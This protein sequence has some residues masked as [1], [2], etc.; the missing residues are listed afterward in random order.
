MRTNNLNDQSKNMNVDP[1][2]IEI[3]DNEIDQ[4]LNKNKHSTNSMLVDKKQETKCSS[5]NLVGVIEE[6]QKLKVKHKIDPKSKTSNVT[7]NDNINNNCNNKALPINFEACTSL[8]KETCLLT[9]TCKCNS[10]SK[11]KTMLIDDKINCDDVNYKIS[12]FVDIKDKCKKNCNPDIKT[13]GSN[14]NK[15]EKSFNKTNNQNILNIKIPKLAKTGQES[16]GL[17]LKKS[18]SRNATPIYNINNNCNIKSL[19][20]NVEA[21]TSLNRKTCLSTLT[22]KHE[23]APKPMFVNNE[24]NSDDVNEGISTKIRDNKICDLSIKNCEKIHSKTDD[25]SI[26]NIKIPELPKTL[27]YPPPFPVEHLYNSD[28]SWKNELPAPILDIKD[29][30]NKVILYWDMKLDLMMAKIN[31]F[32]L[33]VCRETNTIPNSSM[34]IKVGDIKV[35]KLPMKC[36][37]N[38]CIKGCTYYFALRAIDIHKRKAPFTI[39]K[40]IK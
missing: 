10:G 15:R 36:D 1:E 2:I 13:S 24:I 11:S 3:S 8:N 40:I 38:K 37:L 27:Q 19:L 6:C 29:H 16:A 26:I 17:H 39:K 4:S 5:I 34:W 21:C 33:F 18:E 25:Q 23:S 32:E 14:K 35:D 22:L 28:P 30:E 20:I 31:M 9:C 12:T 7:P